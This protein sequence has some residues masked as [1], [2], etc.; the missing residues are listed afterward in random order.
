MSNKNH[1][2][3][4]II[5][6]AAVISIVIIVFVFLIN[7][8]TVW[9]TN[10]DSFSYSNTSYQDSIMPIRNRQEIADIL[11]KLKKDEKTEN[12]S[13]NQAV[14]LMDRLV[15]NSNK[16]FVVKLDYKKLGV[17]S[18][19]FEDSLEM[20]YNSVIKSI[21]ILNS[22]EW[23]KVS[24][25]KFVIAAT[26]Q[27]SKGKMFEAFY[28]TLN[29]LDKVFEQMDKLIVVDLDKPFQCGLPNTRTVYLCTN[30]YYKVVNYSGYVYYDN[31]GQKISNCQCN[32]IKCFE[33]NNL[34]D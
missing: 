24:S 17:K 34:C 30:G 23:K 3:K 9:H 19:E 25:D 28:T 13:L 29:N 11:D 10:Q 16:L 6:S 20:Y 7:K 27:D 21:N 5:A 31:Q 8:T 18:Q 14:N 32:Q 1:S 22:T 4:K 2:W 26:V 33:N 12:L 15:E